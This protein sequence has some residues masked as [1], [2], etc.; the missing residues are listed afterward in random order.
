M[1]AVIITWIIGIVCIFVMKKIQPESWIIYMIYVL[2]IL[3]ML[4]AF[5]AL[6]ISQH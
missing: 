2:V 4:T 6:Y 5:V 1:I 3:I